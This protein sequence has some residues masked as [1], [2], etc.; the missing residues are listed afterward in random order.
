MAPQADPRLPTIQDCDLVRFSRVLAELTAPGLNAANYAARAF[1][2]LG[3]LVPNE[4]SGLGTCSP[5]DGGLTASFDQ[6]LTGMET[7]FTAFGALMHRHAPFRFDPAVHGGRPYSM[8]DCYGRRRFHDLDIYQEVHQ[9][10]GFTDHGFV[11]V[12]SADGA[13]VF[14]GLFRAGGDFTPHEKEMLTLAQPHLANLRQLASALTAAREIPLEPGLFESLGLTPRECE[15]IYWLTQGKTNLEVAL[16]LR[17][18]ADTVSSYL[19]AIYEKLNVEN[20]VAA[21]LV[22][23]ERA[24]AAFLRASSTAAGSGVV[25]F[26]VQTGRR[27]Q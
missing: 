24:R 23:L 21:T 2:L 13:V 17:V 1:R 3:R 6:H 16:L 25:T 18:R 4:L 27:G 14:F 11:Y 12:P 26:Q 19:R 10:M 7:S 20:R 9:P 15:V 8:P 22:A 5:A